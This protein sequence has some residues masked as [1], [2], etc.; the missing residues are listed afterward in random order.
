MAE[1]S[2]RYSRAPQTE[3]FRRVGVDRPHLL[4]LLSPLREWGRSAMVPLVTLHHPLLIPGA[5]VRRVDGI[6]VYNHG[7][8]SQPGFDEENCSLHRADQIGL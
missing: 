7:A 4:A 1:R 2:E 3:N 6:N 8:S 5:R